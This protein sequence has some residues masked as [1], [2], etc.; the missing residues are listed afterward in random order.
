MSRLLEG[1]L[2]VFGFPDTRAELD[3]RPRSTGWRLGRASAFIG[4]G[5]VLAP[6]VGL[7]P[8]HAPWA[9][10]A[11]GISPTGGWRVDDPYGLIT[12]REMEEIRCSVQEAFEKGCIGTD[13]VAMVAAVNDYCLW[14][15][16]NVG[17]VG[18]SAVP[19]A[20]AL[21]DYLTGGRISIPKGDDGD[22]VAS[23]SE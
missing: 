16:M 21:S 22:Q 11:L 18:E 7:F 19:E 23:A 15:K 5:F 8:P 1:T 2:S 3:V 13:E 6:L 12:Q 14:L 9:L 17:V 20:M 4:G 10:A